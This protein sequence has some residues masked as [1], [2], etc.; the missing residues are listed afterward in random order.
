MMNTHPVHDNIGTVRNNIE[1]DVNVDFVGTVD[2][3]ADSISVNGD[4]L[5]Y[6]NS[7]P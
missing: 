5:F 3:S 6:Q 1:S 7:L 4:A 2:Q